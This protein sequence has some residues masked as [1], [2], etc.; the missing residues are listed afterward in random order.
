MAD[1]G[2]E[3]TGTVLLALAMNGL[4]AVAK[5]VAGFISGSGALLSEAAH[6]VAD[7][8]NQ[9]FLLTALK[10]SARPAD[11]QH[12]FGYGKE[13]FFWS[14]IAAVG[15]FV[16]GA[17]FS[18]FQGYHALTSHEKESPLGFYASY[19][20]LGFAL[21]AES[22]SLAKAVRQT[23]R[24]AR[25]ARHGLLE[26]V[27]IS[28]DPTVKTV[29]S[30]DTAAVIGILIA[31]AGIALYQVT[32]NR[33]FDAIASFLIGAL[34]ACVAY[35][36]AR[37]NKD[38][39][40]GEAAEPR[41]RRQIEEVLASYPEISQ[42]VQVLTMRIGTAKM[43]VAARLDL[44]SHLNSDQVEEV[45]T[46]IDNE[47]QRRWPEIDQVFLDATTADSR[48]SRHAHAA[49]RND[50]AGDSSGDSRSSD[51]SGQGAGNA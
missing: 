2:G 21:I 37:D 34:L 49:L 51:P 15:I 38:L 46:R 11:D 6:S 16:A 30:E 25:E 4:I 27:R 17:M 8:M 28:D 20:V 48:K 5:G 31:F 3:S 13:R 14:L 26:H 32:H 47:L 44:A 45:S 19:A 36:L 24:E 29:F 42:V 40:V 50:P 18:F 33:L 7:T 12:P 41:L 10:R 39:L 1:S 35:G 23:R 9:C 43:L 22:A